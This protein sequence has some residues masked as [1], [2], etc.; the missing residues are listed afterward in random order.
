M[1]GRVEARGG[2][3]RREGQ[4]RG[5]VGCAPR[6]SFPARRSCVPN[7][8]AVTGSQCWGKLSH[9]PRSHSPSLS[10][11]RRVKLA[12]RGGGW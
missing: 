2:E 10:L 11:A 7:T 8:N 3:E 12:Q 1:K 5:G 4:G 9:S 6:V